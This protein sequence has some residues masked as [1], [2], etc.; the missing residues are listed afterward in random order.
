MHD[1]HAISVLLCSQAYYFERKGVKFNYNLLK[2]LREHPPSVPLQL[3]YSLLL[4]QQK[5][6]HA[7]KYLAV[8]SHLRFS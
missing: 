3:Y 5:Y 8:E 4:S 1:F 6:T 2:K 7:N